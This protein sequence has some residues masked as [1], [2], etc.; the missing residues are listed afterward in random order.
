[1]STTVDPTELL[2]NEQTAALLGIKPNTLEIWR[3]KGKGPCFVKLGRAKQCRVRYEQE[4][5]MRWL[6]EQSFASTSAYSAQQ[7]P[8]HASC[9]RRHP[10]VSDDKGFTA[11]RSHRASGS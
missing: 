2:D 4:E 3:W 5:V 10:E 1:M 9:R 8:P 11:R 7:P 6:R